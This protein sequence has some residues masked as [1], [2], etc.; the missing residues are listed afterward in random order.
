MRSTAST[1]DVRPRNYDRERSDR[2]AHAQR[3]K[4]GSAL[5]DR[6]EVVEVSAEREELRCRVLQHH[7]RQQRRV[8]HPV[9]REDPDERE[10][11][12]EDAEQHT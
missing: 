1:N 6:S 3:R 10:H 5:E 7:V 2:Q 11:D 4:E 8:H 9:D 12:T